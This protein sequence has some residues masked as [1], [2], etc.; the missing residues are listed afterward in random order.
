MINI[1]VAPASHLRTFCGILNEGAY[2]YELLS[3]EDHWVNHNYNIMTL[4]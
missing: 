2:L 3:A 1:Y 4:M